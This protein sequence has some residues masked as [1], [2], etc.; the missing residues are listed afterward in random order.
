MAMLP[1]EKIKREVLIKKEEETNPQY[2][3]YP[4]KR[5]IT[6]LIR[7]GVINLDKP[8]G[9]TSH[10]VSA[11][12]K[13]ILNTSKAG[14]GGTL[15]PAVTGILP[16]C[17]ENAT[18]V[19]QA[20][21]HAG[22][23]YVT[24]MHLHKD[25]DELKVKEVINNFVGKIKQ[26][27]PA[28]SHVK[29]V[30]RVREIYYINFLEKEG[31]DVLFKVGCQAGTYVRRLCEQIGKELGVNAHMLQLRR[32]K[33]GGFTEED[34]LVTLQD[35]ADAYYY[36]KEEGNEKFLRYCIHPVEYAI[37][38]LPRVWVFDTAVYSIAHGTKLAVPGISKLESGIKK[39]DLVAVLTLKG[40]L[41]GLGIALLS[42]E[43]IMAAEK[44]LAVKV[45][46]VVIDQS[47]YPKLK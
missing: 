24:L 44:G 9:P 7:N 41:V 40:E 2:G 46:R 29:R 18:K 13:K 20:F 14:H 43:Q 6:E 36:Y 32:T 16:V 25:V 17:L 4:E 31:K 27:P 47:A 22:K 19:V 5:P 21:L 38:H 34:H 23:E 12:V 33:A 1:F 26:I 39:D 30:E 8:A 15:D 37:R 35:L 3:C 42:S 45:D 28:R 11:W 10:Q